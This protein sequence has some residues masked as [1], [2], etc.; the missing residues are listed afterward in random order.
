VSKGSAV[1]V[2]RGTSHCIDTADEGAT[3]LVIFPEGD[4]EKIGKDF[5]DET[6]DSHPSPSPTA[7]AN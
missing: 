6:A 4:P 7:P 1:Y 2:P 3:V 5:T